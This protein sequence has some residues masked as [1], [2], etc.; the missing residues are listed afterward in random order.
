MPWETG[1][2]VVMELVMN[3]ENHRINPDVPLA[4]GQQTF[5]IKVSS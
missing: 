3:V 1:F 2:L 5:S 4:Q